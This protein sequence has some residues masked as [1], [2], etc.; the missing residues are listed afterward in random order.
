MP[1]ITIFKRPVRNPRRC[2]LLQ[3]PAELRII[4]FDHLFDWILETLPYIPRRYCYPLPPI[5]RI[6]KTLRN[7]AF[8][9]W[10]G[11]LRSLS[12][13]VQASR[14]D[15]YTSTELAELHFPTPALYVDAWREFSCFLLWQ[16][17]LTTLELYSTVVRSDE[18]G[19]D[20]AEY[21]LTDWSNALRPWPR[22]YPWPPMSL[23]GRN[24]DRQEFEGV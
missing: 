11:R 15:S 23:G 7:E 13:E 19:T 1:R 9:P 10:T 24:H 14:L 6:C 20:R 3:L 5:F 8:Q 21:W 4:I 16:K 12:L 17:Q 18:L 22:L 2:P